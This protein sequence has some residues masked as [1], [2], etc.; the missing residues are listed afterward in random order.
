MS[1]PGITEFEKRISD[2]ADQVYRS[3]K[4][5]YNWGTV[6]AILK[7][8]LELD[9]KTRCKKAN[10][11][12]RAANVITE[13]M[14]KQIQLYLVFIG[15]PYTIGRFIRVARD[16]IKRFPNV[17]TIAVLN[18]KSGSWRVR[19]I[20]EREGVDLADRIRDRFPV[21]EEDSIYEVE[22]KPL[23]AEL[24]L[25]P[26]AND[27][28][29]DPVEAEAIPS[30]PV[31]DE[32]EFASAMINRTTEL[33]GLAELPE[34]LV[35]FAK[36]RGV[37]LDLSLAT[38]LLA[39]TL[40]SQLLMFAGPSGTGKS[41]VARLLRSFFAPV[42]RQ[43]EVEALRQWLTPDDL[44][45]YYSVLGQRFATASGTLTVVGLHEASVAPLAGEG[46]EVEGPPILLVEEMNLSA[47]E[48]Y[49]APVIHGLSGVSEPV[50][51][52]EL[53][54][55]G[56][57]AIDEAAVVTL[58]QAALI[59]PYPRVFGTINVDASAH[60]PARKVAARSSVVLLEPAA[61]TAAE[62]I[63]LATPAVDEADFDE[64]PHGER[65]LGDPLAALKAVSGDEVAIGLLTEKLQGF[66]EQ[67][68][69]LFVSR[70][71]AKRCLA[72]MAYFQAL[73]RGEDEDRV[74]QLA[75]ENAFSHCVLP[76]VESGRF[77][78]TLEAL[79][80]LSLAGSAATPEEMGGL[81]G[82]RVERLL[83]ISSEGSDLGGM[84]DFWSALS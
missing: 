41:T 70:R 65:F 63:A 61:L 43:F 16:R 53:H 10:N 14:D 30:V 44:V 15:E 4:T 40:S 56:A 7:E 37:I 35:A 1:E 36:G 6:D 50:L 60:A 73:R 55:G 13:S 72:Y 82:A 38:D 34:K 42:D 59:G 11:S 74:L 57:E 75:V 77:V 67:L 39:A 31:V 66:V 58:P 27:P 29:S 83:G 3:G 76:T 71:D 28:E 32:D 25:E 19:A 20:I 22:T 17:K 2:A 84:L 9:G 62:L 12:G 81:L 51:H 54:T 78:P 21:L 8:E 46:D 5:G 80:E 18:R 49:L 45:G 68:G 24:P 48:G 26:A 23:P 79:K 69:G 33:E 52:W 64:E 47:P